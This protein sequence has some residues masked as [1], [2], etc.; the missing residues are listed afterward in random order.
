MQLKTCIKKC[1]KYRENT[2]K[3]KNSKECGLA[4]DQGKVPKMWGRDPLLT[5]YIKQTNKKITCSK[6]HNKSKHIKVWPKPFWGTN[7]LK[8]KI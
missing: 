3:K 4:E 7:K 6:F 2:T 1:R 5:I 8:H